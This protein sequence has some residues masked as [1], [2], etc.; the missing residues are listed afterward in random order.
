MRLY[1]S[2]RLDR[3]GSSVS[4]EPDVTP[5]DD[6][7]TGDAPDPDK[8]VREAHELAQAD[9][10]AFSREYVEKLRA[11]AAERRVRA[12][13]AEDLQARL[14]DAVIREGTAGILED[15]DDLRRHVDEATLVDDDGYPD[16]VKVR[17]AAET[18]AATKPHLARRR[19][20]GDIDQGAR[21]ES[22]GDV[23]LA[24]MLRELAN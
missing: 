23:N 14:L 9:D 7:P 3:G 13:R 17:A 10:A 16:V 12:K 1:R 22:S 2:T 15:A 6:A 5:H 4:D 21:P 8:A 20:T 19:P 11:E 24:E 18:I